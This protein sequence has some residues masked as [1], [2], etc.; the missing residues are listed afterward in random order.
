MSVIQDDERKVGEILHATP[1]TTREYVWRKLL[2]VLAAFIG[3]LVFQQVFSAFCYHILPNAKAE[4]YRGPFSLA[5]YVVPALAFALPALVFTALTSFAV[6]LRWRKPI[7]VFVLPVAMILACGFF[8][9]DWSPTWLDPKWNK[10]L[11]ALDPAGF[12]W[13]NETHLKLD[14][15]V[16]FYNKASI[17]FDALFLGSRAALLALGFAAFHLAERHFSRTMRG[18]LPEARKKQLATVSVPATASTV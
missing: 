6:G 18:E 12:R 8:L 1:L 15:G 2:A 7:L 17:P 11:M 13:L 3:V 9:W 5:A 10:L 14:R 16:D 4:E